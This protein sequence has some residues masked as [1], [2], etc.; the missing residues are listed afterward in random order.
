L[1]VSGRDHVGDFRDLHHVEQGCDARHDVLARRRGRRDQRVVATGERNDGRGQRLGET[2][3]QRRGLGEQHLAHAAELGG[4][5]GC[6]LGA[7]AG[8]QHVDVGAD[9]LRGRQ[10]FGGLVGQ[11]LR[12]RVRR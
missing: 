10:R 9:L 2:V 7:V 5:V 3:F 8:D 6:C 1:N 11:G 4:G 12:C